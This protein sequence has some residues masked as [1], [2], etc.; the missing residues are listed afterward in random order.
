[1]EN[2]IRLQKRRIRFTSGGPTPGAL[3]SLEFKKVN[4]HGLDRYLA[5]FENKQ[6]TFLIGPLAPDQKM[7]GLLIRPA[8]C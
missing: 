6:V 3:K 2:L 5:T 7:Q 8:P 1:M 4:P